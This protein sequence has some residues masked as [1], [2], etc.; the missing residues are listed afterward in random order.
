MSRSLSEDITQDGGAILSR[1]P[2]FTTSRA[3]EKDIPACSARRKIVQL[4]PGF[5]VRTGT[6]IQDSSYET[7]KILTIPRRI[8]GISWW[9]ITT[10]AGLIWLALK[11]TV[12]GIFFVLCLVVIYRIATDSL[13]EPLAASVATHLGHDTGDAVNWIMG[14]RPMIWLGHW[15]DARP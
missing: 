1:V 13:F 11:F 9:V 15:M 8:F 2:S 4:I 5:R 12:K 6:K 10:I 7:S 3:H 14:S